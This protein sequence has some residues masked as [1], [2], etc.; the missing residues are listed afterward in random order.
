MTV[1][2]LFHIEA[3][4]TGADGSKERR[5]FLV[6]A[7]CSSEAAARE[8]ARNAVDDTLPPG[9]VITHATFVCIADRDVWQEI[10]VQR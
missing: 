6:S 3:S 5:G 10:G 9:A 2:H 4:V 7:L 8:L 1:W